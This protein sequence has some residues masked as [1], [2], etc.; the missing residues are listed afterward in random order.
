MDNMVYLFVVYVI[1]WAVVFG[2]IFYLVRKQRKLR[3]D[4]DLL[5]ESIDKHK[6]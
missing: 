6:I 1:I 2:Y 4:L 5:K 3:R